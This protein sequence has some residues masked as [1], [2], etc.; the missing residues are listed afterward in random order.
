MTTLE[1]IILTIT[2]TL[3]IELITFLIFTYVWGK[4]NV[5]YDEEWS[6]STTRIADLDKAINP[7][8]GL[9]ENN[10]IHIDIDQVGT[11]VPNKIEISYG[12]GILDLMEHTIEGIV[13]S[14]HEEYIKNPPEYKEIIDKSPDKFLDFHMRTAIKN[15]EYEL[16]QYIK[17]VAESR[18][19]K[20][21]I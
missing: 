21:K 1:I 18:G 17:D 13:E 20:L 2:A 12:N 15:E 10:V 9:K 5:I 11:T 14:T 8:E 6:T 4:K 3:I 16:A 7:F 19:F